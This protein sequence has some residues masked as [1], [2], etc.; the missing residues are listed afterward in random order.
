[1]YYFSILKQK[2]H[3]VAIYLLPSNIF[4][5]SSLFRGVLSSA[6]DDAVCIDFFCNTLGVKDSFAR[7]KK[8]IILKNINEWNTN[9]LTGLLL[10]LKPVI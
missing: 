10:D 2:Y 6:D 5:K 4:L 7:L 1:M 9:L 3:S 8:K